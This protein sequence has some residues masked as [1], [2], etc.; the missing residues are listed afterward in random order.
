MPKK[1]FFICPLILAMAC[2]Q[3]LADEPATTPATSLH[4]DL[5]AIIEKHHLPGIIAGLWDNG[6]MT[7]LAA[8]GVRKV[9][10]PNLMTIDDQMHLGSDTKAM[11]AVLIGQLVE[12]KQLSWQT[13]LAE[14]YPK[15]APGMDPAMAN[16]TVRE[17]LDH[18]AGLPHDVA[19][20]LYALLPGGLAKQR[21]AVVEAVVKMKPET[22]PG[23]AYS[24][25]NVGFVLLGAVLEEKTGK[26]WE[27]LISERL[28][29]PLGMSSAGFGLPGTKEKIDQPWGH[30]AGKLTPLWVDNPAVMDPAGRV[31]C[32]ISDWAKFVSLFVRD[33]ESG[34]IGHGTLQALTTP[35]PA[36]EYSGGWGV[37]DRAWGGGKVLSHSGSNGL[38][39]CVVWAAPLKH[40]S[41]MAATNVGGDEAAAACDEA[42]SELILQR[43]APGK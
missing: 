40:F 41:V 14:I 32:S 1:P 8:A 7:R 19:W 9:G 25:S 15:L 10:S 30:V 12:Q 31:H 18:T 22:A 37:V 17:L 36:S 26:T 27:A 24:Y 23:K 5:A 29:K 42:V 39:Y 43:E 2:A 11:T 3:A 6:Q 20:G 38:W 35:A 13:T 4:N 28:F 16:V 34:I 33:G 21:R